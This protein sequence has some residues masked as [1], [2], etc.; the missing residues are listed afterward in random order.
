MINIRTLANNS[1]ENCHLLSLS[2]GTKILIDANISF[3]KLQRHLKGE[4]LNAALIANGDFTPKTLEYLV[5]RGIDMRISHDAVRS[6][7]IYYKFNTFT[8]EDSGKL[9]RVADAFVTVFDMPNDTRAFNYIIDDGEE[10]VLYISNLGYK[11]TPF[12][13]QFSAALLSRSSVKIII[14][15]YYSIVDLFNSNIDNKIKSQIIENRLSIE[16]A[17]GFLRK[18]DLSNVSEIHLI[19]IS[20]KRGDST[21]FKRQIEKVATNVSVYAVKTKA[22]NRH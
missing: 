20:D 16:Q 3:R 12:A 17:V 6:Y 13:E 14:E 4:N 21:N 9:F 19:N 5:R 18:S 10:I 8:P 11:F 1:K 15:T 7:G 2:N 22:T